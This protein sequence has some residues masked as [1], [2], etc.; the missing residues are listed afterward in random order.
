VFA[1][2]LSTWLLGE[3]VR[4]FHIAGMALIAGGMFVFYRTRG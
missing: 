2:L 4:G 1:S 3:S